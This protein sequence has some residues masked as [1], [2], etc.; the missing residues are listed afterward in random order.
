MP[1][2]E[3]R[4]EGHPLV[5]AVVEVVAASKDFAAIGMQGVVDPV[6][7]IDGVGTMMEAPAGGTD[8]GSCGTAQDPADMQTEPKLPMP[9]VGVAAVCGANRTEPA[10]WDGGMTRGAVASVPKML[11]P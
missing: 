2:T 6:E 10:Q 4:P 3:V 11:R 1:P 8:I 9:A 5:G 7:T